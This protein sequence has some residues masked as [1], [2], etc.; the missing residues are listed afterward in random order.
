MMYKDESA[1]NLDSIMNADQL[2]LVKKSWLVFRRIDPQLIG[3]VF[4]EKLFTDHPALKK[5]FSTSMEEQS[6]KFVAMLETMILH[7]CDDVK[8]ADDLAALALKHAAYHIKQEHYD[9]VGVALI[10]TLKQG[11]GRDWNAE[12]EQAWI[13]CYDML[14]EKISNPSSTKRTQ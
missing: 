2:H 7:S 5:M 4:Y 9:A 11:L 12:T 6:R 14:R 13:A 10:W 1:S 3:S 8:I